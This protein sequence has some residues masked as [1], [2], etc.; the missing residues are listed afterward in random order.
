[1]G[2]DTSNPLGGS[3]Q[4]SELEFADEARGDILTRG[5]NL[6]QRKALGAAGKVLKVRA[7]GLVVEWGDAG[8]FVLVGTGVP[9]GDVANIDFT[10]LNDNP[11]LLIVTTE[12]DGEVELGVQVNGVTSGYAERGGVMHTSYVGFENA[13]QA[14]WSNP[15]S[16]GGWMMV[17]FISRVPTENKA[18][19][20]AISHA[21][22]ARAV[23]M[24][25]QLA[26]QS[27]LTSIKVL[28]SSG[29]LKGNNTRAHL[30]ELTTG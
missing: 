7:D 16:Q 29:N 14:A 23:F 1:L 26:A 3:I 6:W 4:L 21:D 25:G 19:I 15:Q 10:S 11:H 12:L 17:A 2:R 8:N 27:D 22:G 5:I 20:V 18:H 24:T 28:P 13:S 30:Y 9:T